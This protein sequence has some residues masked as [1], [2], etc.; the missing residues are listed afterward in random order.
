[1]KTM[2]MDSG[3]QAW[4]EDVAQCRIDDNI[5]SIGRATRVVNTLVKL[6]RQLNAEFAT[7]F[8]L[9]AQVVDLEDEVK[10][11]W[12]SVSARR[13]EKQEERLEAVLKGVKGS[14]KYTKYTPFHI[15]DVDFNELNEVLNAAGSEHDGQ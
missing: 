4:L 8:K 5:L 11:A 2:T 10:R 3:D 1:M 13:M 15:I 14:C 6:K 7:S 12:D 9:A